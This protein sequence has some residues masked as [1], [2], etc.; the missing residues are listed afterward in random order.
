MMSLFEVNSPNAIPHPLS[1]VSLSP[2]FL[3]ISLRS[4]SFFYFFFLSLAI[5]SFSPSSCSSVSFYP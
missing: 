3:L 2:L 4:V 1:L 5:L